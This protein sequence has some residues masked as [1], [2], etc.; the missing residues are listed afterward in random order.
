MP[1][2]HWVGTWMGGM[3]SQPAG[4]A[5]PPPVPTTSGPDPV[6]ALAHRQL[7]RPAAALGTVE[8]AA[9]TCTDLASWPHTRESSGCFEAPN[10]TATC[11]PH[12]DPLM[13]TLRAITPELRPRTDVAAYD[14]SV[15]V[16]V[17]RGADSDSGAA[18]AQR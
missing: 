3:G 13:S 9:D 15:P 11:G 8:E 7:P 6:Q 5:D 4:L 2:V 10:L 17:L 14:A 12:Y 1:T 18:T 16:L